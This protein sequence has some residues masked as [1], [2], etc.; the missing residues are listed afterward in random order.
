VNPFYIIPEDGME[1]VTTTNKEMNGW[2]FTSLT[3]FGHILD[4]K[5]KTFNAFKT[6]KLQRVL[7][8]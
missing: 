2:H 8:G 7:G 1:N 3:T 6:E 4:L 5:R